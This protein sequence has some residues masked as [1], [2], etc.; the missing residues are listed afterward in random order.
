MPLFVSSQPARPFTR[1]A[2]WLLAA[3]A[4][5]AGVIPWVNLAAA[6]SPTTTYP[7]LFVTQVPVRAD[8][9]TIGSVFGNHRADVQSAT[10]GGDLWIRYPNGTLKNLTAAAGYGSA[11]MQGA[12]AI[13][14]RDPDVYWDG[15]KAVFSM[16]VGA[17]T[18]Q[19]QVAT[20]YWQLYE[21]T[22]LGQ[23]DTPV[24]SKVPR[25][26]ANFNNVSPI[27]GT[28]DRIIFTSDRPR[29]GAAHLYPQLDEYE[30]APTNSGL[31]SLDPASGDLRL[32]NQAPSGDFT[33][34]IDSFGRVLFTQWDH[35]QRD[36]QADADAMGTGNYGTFNYA[37]ESAAAARLT[38]R[39]EV[40]PEPRSTRTDL[41]AGTNLAGHSFNHFFP[42]QINE[43]GTESEVLNHLGRH[44]LHGYIP[45]ALTDDPNL[46]EYYGQYSR[47]NPNRAEN[48][49]QLAEDP[50]QPGRYYAIDAPEFGT[51][52][53]GQ[54]I[55]FDAPPS[56]D[57][58][59]IAIAYVTHRDTASTSATANHSGHYRDPLVLS[60]GTVIAVHT[61][62]MGED[63]KSGGPQASLYDFKLKP[64][65]LGG[66]Y[67]VAGS[68]L[69]GGISKSI[70]YWDPDTLINYAGPLWEM[71]PV[72]VRARPRPQ[73]PDSALPPP[74]QAVFQQVGVDPA[75]LRT[76][77]AQRNLALVVT[78]N[79]TRRD[80]LDKQQPFNLR[81][82]GGGA[83]TTGA[84][85]KIYDVAFA[86]FFQADQLRGWT[87]CCSS[88]P[89]P[90]RR[91]LAQPM[92]DSTARL[93][94][95]ASNGPTGSVAL[96][97]DGSLAAFVPAQR[98]MTWQITDATGTG[99][100]RE[101]YWLTFQPGEVRVC[102]TCHGLSQFDQAGHTAPTNSPEA[103]RQ[104]LKSWKLLI[105]PEN[106]LFVPISRR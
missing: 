45:S 48:L 57:A 102:A 12:N 81:I 69:T 82:A 60:D 7:I 33:P 66:A 55:R 64:L 97:S 14:V 105:A 53:A 23:N 62:E 46:V 47:F 96:A 85:G 8:F 74:E 91:V 26:P 28:D 34:L 65:V 93:L 92:H 77:L 41:L 94:N 86:Q 6:A 75:A 2:L 52:A 35:L 80:D 37:D 58:D 21:I 83:Q 16:V 72:E 24:I 84:A 36:Q 43:D 10:R 31:W 27:Y 1:R 98:A 29:N 44:E 22:G 68:S 42:W 79:V 30:L 3:F 18:Q 32:L 50:Q 51:H 70:S 61:A 17:P 9:T 89:R 19:Y 4:L 63:A 87:G 38:S 67:W 100:V 56:T 104:L 73:H 76:Y 99:V 88:T 106:Q 101:R 25:Q 78:R 20:F 95:I 15:S 103:L 54:V 90:G 13:A 11:G 71:S 39:T 59:H 5:L 40:F 49:L